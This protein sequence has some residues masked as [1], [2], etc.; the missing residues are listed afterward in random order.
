MQSRK[1]SSNILKR[2]RNGSINRSVRMA[3]FKSLP[4]DVKQSFR[5]SQR[6]RKIASNRS[7]LVL[8]S[9]SRSVLKPRLKTPLY[10][11]S[12]VSGKLL[13]VKRSLYIPK[14]SNPSAVQSAKHM[15]SFMRN[16]SV[17]KKFL[18]P[19]PVNRYSTKQLDELV[20]SLPYDLKAMIATNIYR[21]AKNDV[22]LDMMIA[23]GRRDDIIAFGHSLLDKLEKQAEE[24]EKIVR[25]FK[26]R[27]NVT[28]VNNPK[29]RDMLY[30]L[31]R[32]KLINIDGRYTFIEIQKKLP[33][34]EKVIGKKILDQVIARLEALENRVHAAAAVS[35]QITERDYGREHRYS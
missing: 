10:K 5:T 15:K 32:A 23:Q 3:E 16:V 13:S 12:S 6:N 22:N 21:S 9:R 25:Y 27:N 31:R 2:V 24:F 30:K 18:K 26:R 35:D 14:S 4:E 19:M 8:T 7:K 34:I 17:S 20:G 28:Y 33:M 11:R 29:E 1:T